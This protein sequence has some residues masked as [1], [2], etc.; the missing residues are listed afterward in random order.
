MISIITFK[1]YAND[2]ESSGKINGN[3]HRQHDN[4]TKRKSQLVN[5]DVQR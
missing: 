1:K 2:K 5:N 3:V 4:V